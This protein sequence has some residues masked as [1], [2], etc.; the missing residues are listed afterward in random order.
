MLT[1]ALRQLWETMHMDEPQ[2]P[3]QGTPEQ[4]ANHAVSSYRYGC[5]FE[6]VDPPSEDEIRAELARP[7]SEPL[8]SGSIP[9]EPI[10]PIS[11]PQPEFDYAERRTD[12][13]LFRTPKTG[14]GWEIQRNSGDWVPTVVSEDDYA[15]LTQPTNRMLAN[16]AEKPIHAWWT[17]PAADVAGPAPTLLGCS[18]RS[19]WR[20]RRPRRPRRG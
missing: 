16:P 7:A 12:G 9:T 5:H 15:K 4:I 13:D 8:M 18:G 2:D 17:V 20:P 3:R 11:E 14:G 10:E 6:G 19:H 1:H